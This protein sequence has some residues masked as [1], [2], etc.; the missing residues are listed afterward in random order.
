M[1]VYIY[2]YVCVNILLNLTEAISGIEPGTLRLEQ[3]K[4][5]WLDR[6]A[7]APTHS[8]A[9]QWYASYANGSHPISFAKVTQHT[10]TKQ[11][12]VATR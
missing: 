4:R 1:Y 5:R 9:Q 11:R 12:R 7:T 3:G 6:S 2:I 8:T 10:S